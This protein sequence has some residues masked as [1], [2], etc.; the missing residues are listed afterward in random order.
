MEPFAVMYS[1]KEWDDKTGR[2]EGEVSFLFARE[3]EIR[4]RD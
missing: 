4:V 3:G 1:L 2:D